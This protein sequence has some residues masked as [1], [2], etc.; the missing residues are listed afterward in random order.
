MA[1]T[2]RC[3]FGL[4]GIRSVLP[5][6]SPCRQ[7][8]SEEARKGKIYDNKPVKVEL[9][10]AK[11]YHWCTC[12]TSKRQPL[13]DGSHKKLWPSEENKDGFMYIP[14]TFQVDK[15]KE[16][17]LCNC[18]QTANPPYCDGTHK[19]PHIQESFK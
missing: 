16:Y 19:Q 13:C 9:K 8:S 7:L 14:M 5:R 3:A 2:L 11:D 1:A 6:I 15:E 4:R 12:G 18:K 10:A 17:F